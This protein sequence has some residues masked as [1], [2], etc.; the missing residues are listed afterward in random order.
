MHQKMG[1]TEDGSH[2]FYYYNIKNEQQLINNIKNIE[3]EL[4]SIEKCDVY[5]CHGLCED[6]EVNLVLSK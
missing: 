1:Y 3:I 2:Y 5:T 4:E 6:N